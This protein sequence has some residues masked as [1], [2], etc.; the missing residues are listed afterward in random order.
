MGDSNFLKSLLL[1]DRLALGI[2]QQLRANCQLDVRLD[3][4]Q[5]EFF[6]TGPTAVL[7]GYHYDVAEF[8]FN[9]SPEPPCALYITSAL[10][11]AANG[12][13]GY[14]TLGY[15]NPAFDRACHA[16]LTALDQ[17]TRQA[18]HA[19]A[20]AIFSQDLPSL[21]L[22]FRVKAGAARPR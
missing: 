1:R 16:A 18:M 7:Q 11:S 4:Y 17:P 10:S 20:Q 13:S 12:W 5:S 19:Q 15:S 22:F 14:N 2:Q 9:E 8:A 6:E 3:L 21:P